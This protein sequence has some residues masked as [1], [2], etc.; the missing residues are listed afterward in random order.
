[1]YPISGFKDLSSSLVAWGTLML[2]AATFTLVQHN[3]KQE[4]NR[5]KNELSKEKRDRDVA[6]LND[7]I[8]WAVESSNPRQP[9]ESTV[10]L[11][12]I[13]NEPERR[14]ILSA[15][16][17]LRNDIRAM[18]AKSLYISRISLLFGE[19][20]QKRIDTLDGHLRK[21]ESIVMKCQN[22]VIQK[23]PNEFST[24]WGELLDS[25]DP[26]VKLVTEVLD[27]AIGVKLTILNI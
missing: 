8:D 20:L 11:G 14:L 1:M 18:L 21:Q 26:L 3:I 12:D 19:T 25:W 23:K 13:D 7:I 6:L 4:G 5:R 10:I 16:T 9:I 27:T 2:A 22:S 15:L 17:I 24:A